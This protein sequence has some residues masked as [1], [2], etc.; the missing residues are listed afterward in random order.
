MMLVLGKEEAGSGVTQIKKGFFAPQG[1]GS[2][3]Y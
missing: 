1:G 3:Y 2:S